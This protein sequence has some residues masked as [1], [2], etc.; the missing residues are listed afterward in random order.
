MSFLLLEDDPQATLHDAL[1]LIDACESGDGT[2]G[3]GSASINSSS[4]S[5][6]LL[7]TDDDDAPSPP[8]APVNDQSSLRVVIRN[9]P[10]LDDLALLFNREQTQA[11]ARPTQQQQQKKKSAPAHKKE[12]RASA[13]KKHRERKKNEMQ[14]L[15]EQAVQLESR[16]ARLQRSARARGFEHSS[17]GSSSSS[18]ASASEP[19]RHLSEQQLV[20]RAS[21][22]LDF[23]A[24]REKER[25]QSEALNMKLRDALR[26][27]L[28]ASKALDGVLSKKRAE[29]WTGA[30]AASA[31]D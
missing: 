3:A 27:Q 20:P 2:S 26:R 16:L 13:V 1:A 19:T 10:S 31:T 17:R 12:S 11:L 5:D 7:D 30:A 9:P 24:L 8:S 15:R 22:W 21:T 23:A 29:A 28:L 4:S 6:E 18:N 14:T 25:F